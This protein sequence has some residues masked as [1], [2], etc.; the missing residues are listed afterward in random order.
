MEIG[1]V[2]FE[3][4]GEGVAEQGVQLTESGGLKDAAR[5]LDDAGRPDKGAGGR[6]A[7]DL[8][9]QGQ[10]RRLSREW[11]VHGTLLY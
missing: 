9:R 11:G 3:P 5:Q 6:V 1:E 8:Q 4:S 2:G 7:D 10:L